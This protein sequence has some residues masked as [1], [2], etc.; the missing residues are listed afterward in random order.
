MTIRR[1][2]R[3]FAFPTCAAVAVLVP[4]RFSTADAGTPSVAECTTC[5]SRPSTLCVVCAKKCITVEAAYD[6]DGGACTQ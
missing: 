2:I 6:N 4:L 5:C 1:L 3:A